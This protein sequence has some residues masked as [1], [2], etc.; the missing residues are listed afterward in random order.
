MMKKVFL[1]FIAC[2]SIFNLN[3]QSHL[4]SLWMDYKDTTKADTSRAIALLDFIYDGYF[5]TN[6]DS[7]IIL[8][9]ELY[10]FNEKIDY[11][12]GMVDALNLSG[13]LHFRIGEY[14]LAL[15][16][17]N[18]GLVIAEKINYKEGKADILLRTGFLYHDNE[19]I[20]T[21][22]KYY[23][24]SLK[25]FQEINDLAGISSI[26][27]EFGSIYRTKGEY[28]KSLDY[29][30]KSLE[31]SKELNDEIG[32]AAIYDNIGSLYLEQNNFPDA[33][34]Y[35]MKGL[36]LYQQKQDKLGIAA[37]F[38]GIGN[39]YSEQGNYKTAL[40]YLQRSLNINQE[41]GNLLG[42]ST[43]LLDIGEIY[44][45][46]GKY[47]KSIEY[48]T[49]ALKLAEKLGDIGNQQNA[50]D[51]L[52]TSYKKL[53]DI[54]KAFYYLEQKQLFTE[55]LQTEQTAMKVQQIE[56]RQQVV[57]DSLIQVEKDLK[58]EMSY[59]KEI[60]RKNRN[61]NLA[62]G[63][64]I[65]F[66]FVSGGMYSRWNY[67]KKSKA[68]IEK[69]KE[70]SENLLLNILPA[71]IAEEL[72]ETGAAEARDFDQVSI[73]FT[74]FKGFTKKAEQLTA[75]ELIE[76]INQCFKTFDHICT[77]YGVEKIKTIGD[78]YMAAGGLPIGSENATRNTVLAALEM[79]S[80]VNNRILEK[81]A[82]NEIAFE[83]RLGIHT[84]PVVAGIVGIKKFQ[85]DIWGDTVNTAARMESS[86]DIGK[87][88]ISQNTYE[89]LKDDPQ[90]SFEYRGKVQ[91][92]GKGEMKMWF[93]EKI[94]MDS[95]DFIN[96]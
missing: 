69:E 58:T 39:V 49:E 50:C 57:A 72:K 25:I 41:I 81:K 63:F 65:F 47:E 90:F 2:Y 68:I 55:R 19:D 17:Y 76:E 54:S 3:A 1:L 33:L 74:D 84:G 4:D 88:N 96:N 31:T 91:A 75:K 27:N 70:R 16:S 56:F 59:Q 71:E 86:G 92:K 40:D 11:Q 62:I 22:L 34:D 52:S 67:I 30:F 44:M 78:A 15:E 8:T 89:L 14:P 6:P 66:L 48:C 29:Y 77:K 82:N 64:G 42:S 12:K 38:S 36:A 20:I 80:F 87:V 32:N 26:Y 21:G 85:Y 24:R 37:G 7:A 10:Q 43:T 28:E 61:R 46:Q 73:L 5:N 9:N 45:N 83:M 35:Y 93:V 53:G 94:Y 13:F 23:E 60:R 18:K 79:Q 95:K 51:L